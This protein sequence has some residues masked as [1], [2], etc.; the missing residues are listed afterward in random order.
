MCLARASMPGSTPRPV[1][2]DRLRLGDPE[3]VAFLYQHYAYLRPDVQLLVFRP[4]WDRLRSTQDQALATRLRALG[5]GDLAA[6][7]PHLA[8]RSGNGPIGFGLEFPGNSS[9]QPLRTS[10]LY[11]Y[12]RQR[13][14]RLWWACH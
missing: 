9:D 5:I 1:R 4:I 14:A 13:C 12:A 7:F 10:L 6:N 2:R 8:G 11:R 3:V